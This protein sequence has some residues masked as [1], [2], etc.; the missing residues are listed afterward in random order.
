MLAAQSQQ[1][2]ALSEAVRFSVRSGQFAGVN[3]TACPPPGARTTDRL[4]FE[5]TVLLLIET[6]SG[7]AAQCAPGPSAYTSAVY[8]LPGVRKFNGTLNV[9]PSSSVIAPR[10]QSLEFFALRAT[11]T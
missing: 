6:G 9:R 3:R 2:A 4:V 8:F 1:R 5:S 7:F 11:I 10:N